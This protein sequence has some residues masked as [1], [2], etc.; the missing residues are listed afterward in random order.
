VDSRK[1]M[2]REGRLPTALKELKKRGRGR[3]TPL[4]LEECDFL[5]SERKAKRPISIE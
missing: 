1:G 5:I 2:T 4:F 3:E